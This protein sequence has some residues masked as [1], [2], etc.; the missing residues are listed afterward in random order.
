MFSLVKWG[1]RPRWRI[2]SFIAWIIGSGEELKSTAWR[3]PLPL[4]EEVGKVV[5]VGE[6]QREGGVVVDWQV[7]RIRFRILELEVYN[8]SKA[9]L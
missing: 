5:V 2:T 9:Y 7:R 3:I 1:E 4:L 8:S 6:E